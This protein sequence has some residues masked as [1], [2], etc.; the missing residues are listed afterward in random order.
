MLLPSLPHILRSLLAI[1]TAVLP[2]PLYEPSKPVDLKHLLAVMVVKTD[3]SL[4]IIQ[5]R[6]IPKRGMSFALAHQ[7]RIRGE[8]WSK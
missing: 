8:V 1:N 5:H 6:G 7:Y 4:F 3:G 2:R